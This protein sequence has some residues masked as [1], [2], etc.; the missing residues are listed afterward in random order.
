MNPKI[1]VFSG[2][3]RQNSV[4]TQ[5]A[6]QLSSTAQA[7]GFEASFLDLKDYDMPLYDGD[8]EQ[9]QGIPKSAQDLEVVIKEHD[10]IV[11]ASPEYNGAFT[12]LLKNTLDW[13]SRVDVGF[14]SAKTVA[15]ASA[16]PGQGGGARGLA[17]LRTWF[18]NM[19]ISVAPESFSLGSALQ[20]FTNK[21]LE[22]AKQIELERFVHSMV[23]AAVAKQAVAA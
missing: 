15:L 10:I 12:P 6:K 22:E 21:K 18:E 9:S 1:L 23:E 4:N 5:P 17:L 14:L 19:R 13:V 16:S 2:S 3:K 11:I 7:L 8:I 20:A